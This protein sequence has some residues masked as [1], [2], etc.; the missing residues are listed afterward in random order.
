MW[1]PENS[2]FYR[3]N[4]VVRTLSNFK[5]KLL[6]LAVPPLGCPLLGFIEGRMEAW[7]SSME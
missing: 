5:L 7:C 4:P 2:I 3:L 6:G 1:T